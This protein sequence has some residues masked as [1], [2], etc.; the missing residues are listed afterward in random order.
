[1]S[2]GDGRQRALVIGEAL[3]DIVSRPGQVSAEHVGGSPLNVAVGLARL[4]RDVEF[5][6]HIGDDE[7]G[8]RI[9]EYVEAAGVQLVTG[10]TNAARTPTALATLDEH[11]SA[12]Y[13]FDI[14]WQ[15][16]GTPEVG[17]P[18]V[19]HTGSIAT[20]LEPGCRATAAL[21]DTYHPSATVTFDPNVRP[22]LIEDGD[23]ARNR[24]DRII[25]RS[26]V[27]KVSDEDMRWIDPDR[28]A[29]QIAHTWLAM[30][31]SVVA[32]TTGGQGAFALCAQG[33]VRV[34]AFQVDV[35][36]TVGAGDAFM[37]GLIDALWTLGLLGAERRADL[38]RIG[39]EE[40][41]SVVRTAALSSAL[42]VSRAGAD[43]PDRSSRDAAQKSAI[44][45]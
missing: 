36:D 39:T 24:I 4:D 10:S 3:I 16:T 23:A 6:T 19:V 26:D 21:L 9:V 1:M 32:V 5:L 27:V 40:L 34:P 35:V 2:S 37:T 17:P 33:T 30:G 14:E 20:V 31:P 41:T 38:A 8:W 22:V 25:E 13:D 28:S 18:L 15:L 44:L 45:G 11:G 7:R 43:L 42:T 29:E 12:Q